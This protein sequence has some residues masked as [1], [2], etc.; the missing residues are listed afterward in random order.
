MLA[1][2][3]SSSLHKSPLSGDITGSGTN[4]RPAQTGTSGGRSSR[5]SNDRH[6][7]ARLFSSADARKSSYIDTNRLQKPFFDYRHRSSDNPPLDRSLKM[8]TGSIS[9]R[10][11]KPTT[12]VENY[13]NEKTYGV[14][15]SLLSNKNKTLFSNIFLILFI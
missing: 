1:A 5:R 12:I 15:T 14:Y 4:F 13:L 9:D 2:F 11:I 8:Q 10:K 3:V 7:L 6:P